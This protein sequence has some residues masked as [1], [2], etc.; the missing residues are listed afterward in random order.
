MSWFILAVCV[1][2]IALVAGLIFIGRRWRLNTKPYWRRVIIVAGLLLMGVL[3]GLLPFK[4][5]DP[6]Q[7]T[8]DSDIIFLVDTTYSMNA[9]DGRDGDTRLNDIQNDLRTLA[10]SLGGSRF[11][12]IIYERTS[13]IYLPLTTTYSDIDT[14]ADTLSAGAY[15]Y[16]TTDPSLTGA[17]ESTKTYLQKVQEAD[18]TRHQVIVLMTDGELTGKTD[19]A[20]SVKAAAEQLS[21]VTDAALII[22]YGTANG[23]KMPDIR[24]SVSGDGALIRAPGRF[25]Q[26]L[27]NGR[28]TDVV[29]RR[30]E[31]QLRALAT[32]LKGTYVPAQ[33]KSQA[34]TALTNAR[35]QA[36]AR[37][38]ASPESL[39]LRQNLFHVPFAILI[40]GWLVVTEIFSAKRV[41]EFI[42]TWGK[43]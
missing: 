22:G 25:A 16:A 40:I 31:T 37:K 24:M 3:A 36:A 42:A 10:Q 27:V 41:R 32:A 1:L 29:S 11:G 43:K 26:G 34:L 28:F 35:Q 21:T 39:A 38:A 12:M 15:I 9:L 23:A 30:D 6:G 4:P 2:A 14:A 13:T 20:D 33:E 5:L 7:L 17:L 8:T 18:I 19:T